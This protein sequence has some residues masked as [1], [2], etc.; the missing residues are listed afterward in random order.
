MWIVRYALSHRHSIGV[1]ALLLLLLGGLGGRGMSTDILPAVNIP[2]INLIWTYQ[3]LNPQEMASKLTSFSELAV[4]NNV[5]NIREVRSETVNGVGIVRVTFQPGTNVTDAF[6]QVTSVSQTI[7]RRMPPGTNPPL[8]VPY[9]PSSVPIIQLVLASDTLTDGALY[10]YARLA[11]RAQ[12][13]SIPGIRLTLPY[14]GAS[15]QVMIDLKPEALQAY[16]ISAGDIARATA[17]QN[18]TLPSGSLRVDERDITI[19][20]NA[21]PETVANFADLPLRS[22][23]GRVV[24]VSDVASVRDG[25]AVQTNI[26]RLD[27]QNAVIVQILKL[28]DA[29]T[30]DIVQ[31]IH[32]RMPELRAAAPEGITIAPVFD[33]SVFVVN[34]INNVMV[35]A[36]IVGLLVALVVLVF[37]GSWRSSLIV[38]TS[39]PLALLASIAGLA[40]TGNTFNLMTLGGLM[41]AIGILVDNALVE[42]ENINRNLEMGL[43]L[44]EAILKSASEVAFPEFVSTLSICIVFSPLFLLTGT[45]AFVFV[46]LALAVVFAMIA[47]Y[48]L[49]RTLVPTLA[50]LMLHAGPHHAPGGLFGFIARGVD[51]LLGALER[52]IAAIA[53]LLLRWKFIPLAG[54]VVALGLGGWSAANLGREFFPE[55]DAGMIR[56]YL[57]AQTGLRLEETAVRFADVQREILEIIPPDEV[58]FIAENIGSPEPI[59]LGWVE[60]GVIGSFDGEMLVQ[61]S[62]AHAPTEMYVRKIRQMLTEKFPQMVAYFRPADATSQTLA[63]SAQ[64]AIEVRLIGRDRAGNAEIAHELM[65][66][67]HDIP[68][69]VDV[70]QR[71]VTDLPSYYLEIDRVRALQIGV[72]PQDAATALLAALGAS[73]TVSPSFWSDPEQGAAYTV[74]VVAPP[75]NLTSLE[76]LL[77]TP[78]RP[79]A[80][81]EPVALR[82]FASLQMRE[83]AANIDR[84]TLQ[85]TI[86]ILANVEGRDLGG[87]YGDVAALVDEARAR[88]KPGNRIVIAGQAQSM[89]QAYAEMLGGLLMASIFVYLVMVV[90]FQ[91][92]IMPAIAMGGLPVA[93]SGA[94]FA[95]L[96][97]GTAVSVP[98]LTGLIMV[99]GVS[100][101]NS[102]L[103]TS[104]ARDLLLEGIAPRQA[105]IE[106]ART[107]LRPVLMTA[108]AMIVGILPMALGHGDGGEQ[109]APLGRAVVGGLIFGT[110][111]TLTFVPFLFATLAGIGRRKQAASDH[112]SGQKQEIAPTSLSGVPAE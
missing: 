27:G 23:D 28:G 29:S 96:L 99:I 42:I 13:Q 10:D 33:Q 89:Q 73:G 93:I 39:I 57:R 104:F 88:L 105:A 40:L 77:N 74:Q 102:V 78:V 30:L 16:G 66:R 111:A 50:S 82:T 6:A 107:R 38:L 94:L 22:V 56:I 4:M 61:L 25:Q 86:T 80:G 109:N 11:L 87:V 58:E 110:C 21:S 62:H 5:D 14:G 84:T 59:N 65:T 8:I 24:R 79:S 2:A 67:M 68:G 17:T 106:A 19:T 36:V 34:A 83:I 108:T 31:Q 3:G 32:A 52:M 91:S 103:V 72:T 49:S 1:L 69:A 100:T 95:L 46:P 81:G 92:W 64:T 35:E 51:K 53:A 55:T 70:A 12:I 90:N 15:R 45:A 97:T 37:L 112:H 54:L 47:S 44:N 43:P 41:L 9:V 101:A 18:L 20:T 48:V 71:Q 60:S 85:P 26:A 98:A 76:Q 7:L 63:G 75:A